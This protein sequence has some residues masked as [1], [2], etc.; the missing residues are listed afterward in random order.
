M[1][2]NLLISNGSR[3]NPN[4]TN[5]INRLH[6]CGLPRRTTREWIETKKWSVAPAGFLWSPASHDA[7]VD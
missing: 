2:A 1:P 7:G 5:G 6:F 3:K 4:Y